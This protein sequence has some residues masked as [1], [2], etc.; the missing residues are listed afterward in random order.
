MDL[1]VKNEIKEKLESAEEIVFFGGA[2]TSTE[3]NIPDFDLLPRGFTRKT[4]RV[5]RLR[6]C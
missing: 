6:S 3:S 1:T 4:P 5:I 2:G